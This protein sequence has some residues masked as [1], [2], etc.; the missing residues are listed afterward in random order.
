MK[1]QLSDLNESIRKI[2]LPQNMQDRPVSRQGYP[3]P[4]FAGKVNGEWDFRVTHPGTTVRCLKEK[5]CWVCGKSMGSKLAFVVGPMCVITRTSAEPPS[6]YTCGVY[7]AIA[8]PFLASPRMK[9]NTVELPEDHQPPPGT[10]I[11]RNPGCAA[12][13]VTNSYK[14]FN[15][16]DGGLLIEM[17]KPEAVLWFARKGNATFTDV[18]TSIASGITELYKACEMEETRHSKEEAYDELLLRVGETLKWLPPRLS[19]EAPIEIPA[20]PAQVAL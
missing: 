3:V 19:D 4:F 16:G 20:P 9:R 13:L 1:I 8:C 11:M 12:V 7:S 14:P 18:M 6:H 10:A 17:G 5:L 2:P 15:D